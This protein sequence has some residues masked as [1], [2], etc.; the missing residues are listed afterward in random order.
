MTYKT[1]ILIFLNILLIIS[2]VYFYFQYIHMR[3]MYVQTAVEKQLHWVYGNRLGSII[4]FDPTDSTHFYY[5][6]DGD[7]SSKV[8]S[9]IFQGTVTSI[10]ESGIELGDTTAVY[11]DSKKE[12]QVLGFD[13]EKLV[14]WIKDPMDSPGPC[15]NPWIDRAPYLHYVQTTDMS[16][17]YVYTMSRQMKEKQDNISKSCEVE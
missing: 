4:V 1:R 2:S 17:S 12:L 9:A 6:L 11:K 7:S 16:T 13:E 14:F 5:S 3:K 10:D 15:T 8:D